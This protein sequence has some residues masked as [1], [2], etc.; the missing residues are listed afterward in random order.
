MTDSTAPSSRV[1]I[2]ACVVACGCLVGVLASATSR[3]DPPRR[4]FKLESEQVYHFSRNFSSPTRIELASLQYLLTPDELLDLLSLRN[5]SSCIRWMSEFWRDRDPILT[6]P[7]NEARQEHER[8]VEFA[9]SWFG[10]AEWPG[11]DQRGEVCIRYGL[12]GGR[13]IVTADVSPDSYVRPGEYWFYPAFGMTVQFE[14]AFGNGNYTYYLERVALPIGERWSS[15]RLRMPAGQW[16]Q[17][18]DLD[19]DLMTLDVVLGAK[20]GYFG[21]YGSS[22]QFTYEDFQQSLWRFPEVLETTPAVFPFDFEHLRVPFEFDVAYFRGGEALDRVDVNAEFEAVDRSRPG[23]TQYRATAVF[24]D[25][26]A[27]EIARVSHTTN[28]LRDPATADSLFDVVMQLPS[29]LS[30]GLYEMAITIEESGTGRFSSYRKNVSLDD[31]SRRLA[32]STVCFTSRIE[33]VT[34]PSAFNRGALEVVPKPSARYDVA[35][36]VPVYFEVYNLTADGEGLHRYQVSYRVMPLTPAP[37]G[38][39]KKIVGGSEEATVLSSSFESAAAGP[40]DVVYV[41]LKTDELWPGEFEFDVTV[42]DAV[43]LQETARRGRFRIVE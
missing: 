7:E 31:F 22:D 34:R 6:T 38:L 18:P 30:P 36:S 9:T 13:D 28:V 5:E 10:R 41:F 26:D 40:H 16:K 4:D 21:M 25:L 37:K 17:M 29:T 33:P 23:A 8:R 14:D 24:F 15:D 42:V 32:M 35:T 2:A 39:W 3:A 20:G 27:K 11:W 12:P 43:S 19:L 1:G